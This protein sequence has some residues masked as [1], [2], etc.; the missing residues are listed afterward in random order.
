MMLH[1]LTAIPG[2]LP[3][4]YAKAI[5]ISVSTFIVSLV[6]LVAAALLAAAVLPA[7]GV[8][9]HLSDAGAWW[10]ILGGATYLALLSVLA[11]AIGTVV[12]NS[13]GGIATV[14]ALILV[15]HGVLNI[16]AAV[17]RVDWAH[18]LAAFLPDAAGG[19]M[20]S[21]ASDGAQAAA[22]GRRR[23]RARAGAGTAGHG[24]LGGRARRTGQRDAEEPRRVNRRPRTI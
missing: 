21:Y 18:D 24:R 23:D 17:A 20:Y 9:P 7:S 15:L 14:L 5:I 13:A 8:T 1:E 22:G 11:L 10:A 4:L 16:V 3:A 6:A 2:R 19:R 12:R